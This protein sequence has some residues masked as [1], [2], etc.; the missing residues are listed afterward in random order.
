MSFFTDL[1]KKSNFF[2]SEYTDKSMMSLVEV[3]NAHANWKSRLNQFIAGTLT[4][5]LDPEMLAQA[6]DTELGRWIIQSDSLKMSDERR[7]LIKQLHQANAELHQ[8]A[9]TIARH[10]HAGDQA[11]I[12]NDNEQFL[13][14]SRQVMMLLREL[15]KNN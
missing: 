9:S 15:G 5:S 10:I 1:F 6:D 3:M 8:A 12:A 7:S 4:Y 14:A 11:G 13:S 2:A